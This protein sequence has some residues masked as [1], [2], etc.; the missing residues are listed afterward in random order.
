MNRM[1]ANDKAFVVGE[2]RARYTEKKDTP[3]DELCRLDRKIRRPAK[4]VA[5][6][7]GT[8]SALLMGS[9]MSLL[10]TEL[11]ASL[12]IGDPTL[13]GLLLGIF[14]L[15]G[16]LLNYPIYQKRQAAQIAAHREEILSLSEKL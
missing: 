1:N 4:I 6:I 3:L 8:L 5:Y 15:A 9:G 16:A 12:G 13:P 7:F 11:A 14:G 10:M 2:I